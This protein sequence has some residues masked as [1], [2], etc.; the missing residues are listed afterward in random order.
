[1]SL[2][3][4]YRIKRHNLIFTRIES[5]DDDYICDLC[6]YQD[7]CGHNIRAICIKTNHEIIERGHTD[8]YSYVIKSRKKKIGN[9]N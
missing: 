8:L 9:N 4:H 3:K 2:F 5:L 7:H 6:M 1:M